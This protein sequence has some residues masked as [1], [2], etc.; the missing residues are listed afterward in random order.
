MGIAIENATL[1][2]RLQEGRI[3]NEVL[4]DNLVTGVVAADKDGRVTVCNREAQRILR[5]DDPRK[6]IGRAAA[7][8]LPEAIWDEVSVSLASGRVVRDR[9]LLL[10][11]QAPDE[12]SVRF[13]TALFGG[14]GGVASGVL[15][16]VQDTSAIRRLEEQ[17]RRSD[18]LASIGTLAAGMAHEI[19]NP[20]VCLKTFAQL[21][22][23]RYDDPD[24]RETFTP[25]LENEVERINGIV[26]QLL[27]F[28]RPVKPTLVPVS[29]HA[30]LDAAWQ[31]AAQQ[32]KAKGLQFLRRYNAG[33]DR[34]LGDHRLLGQVFLNLFLNG[35]DAMESGGTLTVSTH[36]IDPPDPP[37][38]LGGPVAEVWIEVRVH[39]SGRGVAPEDRERIFDPFF[40]T[41]ANGTGL[42]LSVAHGI[43]LE[44]QGMID[45][46]S[47]LGSGTCF[48]VL[49]PLLASGGADNEVEKGVA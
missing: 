8:V 42:G 11:P 4:L 1:Y 10:R 23:S 5:V 25:L 15:L 47:A 24:F 17:I 34:L 48:R 37:W 7:S 26:S 20:L 13:A 29:L 44:H 2:T 27:N 31:L 40:T 41:K 46:E 45:V 3:Y 16:V 35:I 49:L 30:A 14:E 22:P 6:V 9:N 38:H 32:V 28:S 21:L 43:I 19:K 36:T 33:G 12:Q 39:D 18:R